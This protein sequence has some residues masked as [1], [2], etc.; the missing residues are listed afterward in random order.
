MDELL[1]PLVVVAAVLAIG[2]SQQDKGYEDESSLGYYSEEADEV[3]MDDLNLTMYE[4]GLI[5]SPKTPP[6]P[7]KAVS[8]IEQE[9]INIDSRLD[10]LCRDLTAS[11][12]NVRRQDGADLT[13]IQEQFDASKQ[14]L[15]EVNSPE[16]D[17][18]F[19]ATLREQAHELPNNTFEQN[20]SRESTIEDVQALFSKMEELE[21]LQKHVSDEILY[22][23]PPKNPLDELD[24]N[25]SIL[26]APPAITNEPNFNTFRPAVIRRT[27]PVRT[28][29]VVRSNLSQRF[30][31]P[32][33]ESF[34][35]TPLR[36]TTPPDSPTRVEMKLS[37]PS[38][39]F[40]VVKETIAD[41]IRDL[42]SE[43]QYD[44]FSRAIDAVS[45]EIDRDGDT[46][47]V[48]DL[49]VNLKPEGFPDR[50]FFEI[51]T[52]D[53]KSVLLSGSR[54]T[55]SSDAVKSSPLF[56]RYRGLYNKIYGAK[57]TML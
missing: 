12:D 38:K 15:R 23:P 28:G 30:R 32:E 35:L 11:I 51:V 54:K 45:D 9:V 6:A 1:I 36:P 44:N 4:R 13:K 33:P 3:E 37:R 47:A 18:S 10:Q 5:A 49:L 52:D 29:S 22:S 14:Y 53:R 27:A 2:K 17:E 16:K 25:D 39:G 34:P 24:H 56:K 21:R 48:K 26:S 46:F 50:S 57:Q 19:V 7:K 55:I 42:I 20:Q 41:P 8:K 40:S 31:S 43:S